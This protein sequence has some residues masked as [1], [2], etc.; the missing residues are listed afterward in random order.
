MKKGLFL[1]MPAFLFMNACSS[2]SPLVVKQPEWGYEKE[3]I[4][5][6]LSGDPQLNLYQARAHS[7]IVC[8]Y[9]LKDLNGFNQL[10]DERDGLPRLLECGRFDQ[11]VTYAKRL[12]LQPHKVLSEPMDRT[13]GARYVGIVAGYYTLRKEG[14]VRTFQVPVS[15][16]KRKDVLLQRPKKLNI[17][18]ALGAQEIQREKE[19]K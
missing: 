6:R 10:M 16:E 12:V 17:D 18:L 15:E 7:L 13:E 9:H 14:C 3:A 19:K 8:V 5:L 11:N 4:S 2:S 1:L